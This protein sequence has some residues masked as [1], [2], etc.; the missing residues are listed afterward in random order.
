[1]GRVTR[2]VLDS[3]STCTAVPLDEAASCVGGPPG[4]L[5][6]EAWTRVERRH[7]FSAMKVFGRGV[8][9]DLT[10]R[11]IVFDHVWPAIA[12]HSCISIDRD[13]AS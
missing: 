10:R 8:V 5:R 12:V 6:S 2:A 3:A 13:A 1:M 4:R 9:H 7:S 11:H